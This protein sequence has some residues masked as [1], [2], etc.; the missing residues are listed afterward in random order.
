MQVVSRCAIAVAITGLMAGGA[1][2]ETVFSFSGSSSPSSSK[3]FM[4]DGI[5][6]VATAEATGDTELVTQGLFG[7]G[8]KSDGWWIFPDQNTIDGIGEKEHLVLTFSEKVVVDKIV[9]GR[10]DPF[11][12]G[13][14]A[15]MYLDDKGPVTVD[16]NHLLVDAYN[17]ADHFS[18]S[19]RTGQVLK[20]TTHDK[21]DN[22]RIKKIYVSKVIPTPSAALAGLAL[23][24]LCVARRRRSAA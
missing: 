6:V 18:V 15:V 16:L 4:S 12:G 19:E 24:G 3:S 11:F 7:L 1:M 20:F 23:M 13:D 9:F 5:E 21:S 22:Y 17:V 8:V 14:Q 10:T 2:A